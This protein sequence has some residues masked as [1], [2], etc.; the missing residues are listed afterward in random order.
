M[1]GFVK[2]VSTSPIKNSM[3]LTSENGENQQLKAAAII[4]NRIP[5]LNIF[6]GLKKMQNNIPSNRYA[7]NSSEYERNPLSTKACPI[8]QNSQM[9]S[10]IAAKTYIA[11]GFSRFTG[12]DSN[13][14]T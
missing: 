1:N 9:F 14:I 7:K 6:I 4:G 5:L 11:L 8:K 12:F 3:N 10:N 2:L 13:I